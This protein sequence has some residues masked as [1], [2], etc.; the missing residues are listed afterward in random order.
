MIY[1]YQ[2]TPSGGIKPPSSIQTRT[3]TATYSWEA[4]PMAT[5]AYTNPNLAEGMHPHSGSITLF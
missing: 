3:P 5:A 2:R 1:H 4:A